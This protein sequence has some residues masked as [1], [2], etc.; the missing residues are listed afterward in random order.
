MK[1]IAIVGGGISGLTVA[2]ALI[3]KN[4]PSPPFAKG[5]DILYPPLKKGDRGGFLNEDLDIT[6]LESDNRPGGKIWTDKVNGFLCEKGPNG[7]LDNKPKTLELC[8]DLGIEPLRSN[9]NAKKRY[10]FSQGKLNVLPES[11]LAF[12]KSDLI[13]WHGKL[14]IFYDLIAPKGPED[15]TV[16]DFVIRRLCKEALEKLIDPMCS[17]IFAGDPYKMSIRHCFPRIKEIEQEYGSLIRGMIKLQRA[18][19]KTEAKKMRSYEDK[20]FSTSQPLNFS[21]SQAKVGP[22]PSGNLTS[23]YNGT[24]TITDAL[25]EKLDGRVRIGVSVKG[26]EKEGDLYRLHTSEGIVYA[27]IVVLATPAYASSEILRDFDKEL[28]K[29]LS[30]ISYPPVSVVCF[31][32]KSEKILH[33]LNG[34]GFLI[35]HKEGKKILGT[36]WDSSIFPNRAT[37][38]H[39]LLRSMI[40]GA[41]SPELAMLED[42]DLINTVFDELRPIV[43]LKTE[44]DMVRIYRWEKAIPQYDLRH[45]EKL[46][47]IDD[48]LKS[49][50]GLYL[51]GNAYRGIGMNDCIENGYKI[52]DEI[53]K[54]CQ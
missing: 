16:A 43:S 22:A 42:N 13:S 3:S 23:F 11:P 8:A 2:Y 34:F 33:P 38:G 10:I 19:K 9:E 48:R 46:R 36:L 41:K 18:K 32:Y 54:K 4:P 14:R 52:A 45:G 7:F 20:N 28:S 44:P 5:G 6:V 24:Q 40:G 26:L 12:L 27:D 31:G 15:E 37:E 30:G 1:K 50:P 49:C 39:V 25:T 51:T 29:N 53:I 21:T 17:G 47:I 35:P